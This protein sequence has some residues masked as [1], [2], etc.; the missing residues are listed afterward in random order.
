MKK[1]R[2]VK[3]ELEGNIW[4]SIQYRSYFM[5]YTIWQNPNE[6]KFARLERAKECVVRFREGFYDKKSIP[7]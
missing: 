7:I 6:L 4:Y 5:W 3:N 1:Y 2:I